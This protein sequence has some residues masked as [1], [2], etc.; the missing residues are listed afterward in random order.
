M[1]RTHWGLYV[2][3]DPYDLHFSDPLPPVKFHLIKVLQFL[4][5]EHPLG[6]YVQTHGPMADSSH[7]N[8]NL[9]LYLTEKKVPQF[10]KV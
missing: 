4:K 1:P 8:K 6:S 5:T 2:R 7:S 3:L 9:K 10:G